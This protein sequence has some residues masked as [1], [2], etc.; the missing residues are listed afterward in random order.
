MTAVEQEGSYDADADESGTAESVGTVI[1]AG[2]VNLAIA[3]AKLVAGLLSGS[4]AMLSEAAHSLADTTTEV[5]LYAALRHGAHPADED[6]PFG[7]GKATYFWAFLAAMCTLVAGAGFGIYHGIATIVHGEEL[8]SPVLSYIVLAIA[9]VLESVSF[10][11]AVSQVRSATRRWRTTVARYLHLTG[12]TTVKAVAFEDAAALIGLVIAALG[13]FLTE[14][15]GDTLW[16][17]LASVAIGALLV[18]VVVILSR[19]NGS[20]LVGRAV[21]VSVRTAVREEL[22]RTDAIVGVP[23]LFTMHLGPGVFLVAAKV[24]FRDD[25]TAADLEAAADD[26]ERRLRERYPQIQY[27]FL[28]PTP[29][30]SA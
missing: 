16:D 9:F 26:A 2:L 3:V 24:D 17:G 4:A 11:R 6:H 23:T 18:V 28:D 25:A 29:G 30:R 20:L 10:A 13:V 27:V 14:V 7:Y 22:E 19:S 15:T 21:P 12:D 8:G 5:L 1:V